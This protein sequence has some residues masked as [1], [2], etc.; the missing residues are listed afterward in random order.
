MKCQKNRKDFFRLKTASI[1]P[2]SNRFDNFGLFLT[3]FPA[4]RVFIHG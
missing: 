4:K 2:Y 1:G 3:V